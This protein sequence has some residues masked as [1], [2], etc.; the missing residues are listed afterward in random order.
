LW[1]LFRNCSRNEVS[2]EFLNNSKEALIYSIENKFARLF[3]LTLPLLDPRRPFQG[4]LKNL[5]VYWIVAGL[6]PL[7]LKPLSSTV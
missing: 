2:S 3:P 4:K 6:F 7:G 1:L 5:T